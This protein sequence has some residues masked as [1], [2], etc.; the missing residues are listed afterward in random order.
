MHVH[1]KV[2]PYIL[3]TIILES[4]QGFT[5]SDVSYMYMYDPSYICMC[6]YIYVN[7]YTKTQ[8]H[9]HKNIHVVNI[10]KHSL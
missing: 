2:E 7:M 3:W 9:T 10:L 8:T 5:S 1:C 4:R 6:V